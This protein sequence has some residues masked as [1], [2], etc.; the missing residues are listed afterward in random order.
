MHSILRRARHRLRFR[1]LLR[2]EKGAMQ[3]IEC[4]VLV[5]IWFIT[6]DGVHAGFDGEM[7]DIDKEELEI[8]NDALT[9][10]WK[11]SQVKRTTWNTPNWK[12]N[13]S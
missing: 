5:G 12:L 2:L 1:Y 13:I 6:L 3:N 11:A 7:A 10:S 4:L 8:A 9:A